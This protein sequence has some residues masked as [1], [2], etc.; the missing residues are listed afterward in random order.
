MFVM[1][2]VQGGKSARNLL[3]TG[4]GE[5]IILV[6]LNTSIKRGSHETTTLLLIQWG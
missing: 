4:V 6:K 2:E 1:C 3:E 5:P